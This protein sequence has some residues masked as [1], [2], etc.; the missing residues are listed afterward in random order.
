MKAGYSG[1]FCHPLT[2]PVRNWHIRVTY[3]HA[4]IEPCP[5][6]VPASSLR[7]SWL[8]NTGG[9]IPH[10]PPSALPTITLPP[11]L[12]T[13]AAP[14]LSYWPLLWSA[15]R[16]SSS[17]SLAP[18][19][20][21]AKTL[22]ISPPRLLSC[23][24]TTFVCA[25]KHLKNVFWLRRPRKHRCSVCGLAYSELVLHL[26]NDIARLWLDMDEEARWLKPVYTEL[27]LGRCWFFF[28]H[29]FIKLI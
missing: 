18:T 28:F 9:V 2:R 29:P 6:D 12:A 22:I 15:H 16:P 25:D 5:P 21:S 17:S 3:C 27:D 19:P 4:L 14:F 7:R 26:R 1:Q 13:T 20:F 10:H 23:A 24:R 11:S 8:T